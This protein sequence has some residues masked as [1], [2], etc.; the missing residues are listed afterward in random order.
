M[1]PP[2]HKTG[3]NAKLGL[4]FPSFFIPTMAIVTRDGSSANNSELARSVSI[5]HAPLA[6]DVNQPRLKRLMR[7]MISRLLQRRR[8]SL[9]DPNPS[10][11]V[12]L[13]PALVVQCPEG[14]D[15]N[16][17]D[18]SFDNC[19]SPIDFVCSQPRRSTFIETFGEDDDFL[20]PE[21]MGAVKLRRSRSIRRASRALSVPSGVSKSSSGRRASLRTKSM[22]AE[23][24]RL[25]R[26]SRRGSKL[27][28]FLDDGP[29]SGPYCGDFCEPEWRK[30][31][32]CLLYRVKSLDLHLVLGEDYEVG[33]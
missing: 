11:T 4:L 17:A 24:S 23:A 29:L 21:N 25:A 28:R 13:T 22:K 3:G 15:A 18:F 2:T 1:V 9:P 6:A 26:L 5:A 31:I 7:N 8:R 32:L 12:R 20:T 19:E 33:N 27:V 30:E 10:F 16:S 14:N